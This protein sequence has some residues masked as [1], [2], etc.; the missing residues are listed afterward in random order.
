MTTTAQGLSDPELV[1]RFRQGDV[2]SL[3]ALVARHR[4][5]LFGYI[6][7]MA[8]EN[9]DSEDTFQ[10]VWFRVL[11]QL[12]SYRHDNFPGWLMRIAHN[13]VIDQA[14][15]TKPYVHLTD[16]AEDGGIRAS[17]IPDTAPTPADHAHASDLTRRI[18]QAVA[19]L[20]PEQ[21][22]VFLMR[23]ESALPFKEIARIH[24]ISINTALGRMQFALRRLQTA[25]RSDYECA[26]GLTPTANTTD[27]KE[28]A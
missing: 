7:S 14:R 12:Q 18:A 28:E 21:K 20:P 26:L 2:D 1:E 4:N 8:A 10:E 13:V 5:S 22:S 25:L 24:D 19:T 16:A 27:D 15:K 17:V 9:T 23:T 11:K 6:H 3:Q